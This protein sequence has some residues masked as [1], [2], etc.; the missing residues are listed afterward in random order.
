MDQIPVIIGDLILMELLQGAKTKVNA[1]AI[2]KAMAEFQIIQI[3][4]ADC[5]IRASYYFRSLRRN[6]TTVLKTI[7]CLIA[8]PCI[9]NNL[10][11]LSSDRDFAPFEAHFGLKRALL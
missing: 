7:D 10:V 11:L 9:L 2:M 6:G 4:G 1:A 8:T 5:A 3:A